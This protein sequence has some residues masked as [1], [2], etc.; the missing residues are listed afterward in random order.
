M[1]T[2]WNPQS[3]VVYQPSEKIHENEFRNRIP[4]LFNAGGMEGADALTGGFG[5][6]E[7]RKRQLKEIAQYNSDIEKGE[8]LPRKFGQVLATSGFKVAS[9]GCSLDW[10]LSF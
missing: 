1:P 6:E 8:K 5:G 7:R 9:R 10:S 4:S 3:T 2:A